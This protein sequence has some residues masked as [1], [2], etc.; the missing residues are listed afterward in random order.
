M[1]CHWAAKLGFVEAKSLY[2]IRT[3]LL[4]QIGQSQ[5]AL[6]LVIFDSHSWPFEQIHQTD[7]SQTEVTSFGVKLPFLVGCHW[8]ARE[9]FMVSKSL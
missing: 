7:L 8:A 9:G 6:R 1:G 4:A 5:P 3:F 2:P